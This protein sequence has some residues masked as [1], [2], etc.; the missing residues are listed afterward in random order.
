M[1]NDDEASKTEIVVSEVLDALGLDGLKKRIFMD[2]LK[3]NSEAADLYLKD[4]EERRVLFKWFKVLAG[5]VGT[6]FSIMIGFI[7]Y[8][9]EKL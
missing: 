1:S 3:K 5:F 2:R 8:L 7:A 4:R 6:A 9:I